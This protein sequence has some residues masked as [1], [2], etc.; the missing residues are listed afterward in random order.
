LFALLLT[1]QQAGEASPVTNHCSMT[2]DVE[3]HAVSCNLSAGAWLHTLLVVAG[4]NTANSCFCLQAL[5]LQASQPHICG[6]AGQLGRYPTLLAV[7]CVLVGWLA[8]T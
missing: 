5:H 2:A 7:C 3:R 1:R 6:L 8:A 4:M